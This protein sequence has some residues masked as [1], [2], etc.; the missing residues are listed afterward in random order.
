[1]VNYSFSKDFFK[2]IIDVT[3]KICYTVFK[4]IMWFL[5]NWV[6]FEIILMVY[7]VFLL[8]NEIFLM[9]NDFL[10]MVFEVLFYLGFSI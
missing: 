1:M 2:I 8:V 4:E 10:L 6:L 7:E 9:V 5:M 3:I